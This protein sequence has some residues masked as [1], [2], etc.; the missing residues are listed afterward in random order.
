MKVYVN[1]TRRALKPKKSYD[2]L[3]REVEQLRMTVKEL[4]RR[5]KQLEADRKPK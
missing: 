2:E 3:E 4:E 5:V 1:S